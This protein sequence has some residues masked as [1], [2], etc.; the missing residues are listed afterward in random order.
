MEVTGDDGICGGSGDALLFEVMLC[1]WEK[2]K[3]VSA[4]SG[5]I[6][7]HPPLG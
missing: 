5:A 4:A 1:P 2:A 7:S 6:V 3:L